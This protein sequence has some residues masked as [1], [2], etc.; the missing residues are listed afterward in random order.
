M[1]ARGRRGSGADQ[2]RREE[3]LLGAVRALLHAQ[4]VTHQRVAVDAHCQSRALVGV[5]GVGA[6]QSVPR[7]VRETDA[8]SQLRRA[9]GVDG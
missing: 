1:R 7:R 6:G 4:H 2:R 9:W 5:V 3:H 8:G